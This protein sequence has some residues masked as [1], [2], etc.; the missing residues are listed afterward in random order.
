M[1]GKKDPKFYGGFFTDVTYKNLTLNAVFN[2]SYGGKAISGLYEGLLNGTGE[3][4]GHEDELN[5]WTP[6]NT[7]S[8]IPRAY[9]GSGRYGIGETDYAVQ[10]SSYLRMSA[11]TLAY[12]FT[13]DFMKKAKISNL[14]VYVT[15]RNLLTV[16]KY[17]GYDPEGGDGYPTSKMF[18]F[19]VNIGL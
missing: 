1:V 17:K 8:N 5:R 10:N 9:T 12:N 18:V 2:Y 14:R 6:T 13:Q 19:G 16:T 15:G 7:S 4:S 3:Y 11:L